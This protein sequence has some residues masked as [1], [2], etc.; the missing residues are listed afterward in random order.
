M[1]KVLEYEYAEN[2]RPSDFIGPLHVQFHGK[3]AI[4]PY[5]LSWS[6]THVPGFWKTWSARC[7]ISKY[8]KGGSA[9][10]VFSLM[11]QLKYARA[12]VFGICTTYPFTTNPSP[13]SSILKT[14][15][16]ICR[17]KGKGKRE[18]DIS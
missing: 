7:Y 4:Q 6:L 1:C 16:V 9:K 13:A 14:S 3:V 18:K 17:Q 15:Q 5:M 12:Q 2:G 10:V 11:F 8:G